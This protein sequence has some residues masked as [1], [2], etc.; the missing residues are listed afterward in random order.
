MI[1]S[2][3]KD[4]SEE[5]PC[6]VC[7]EPLLIFPGDEVA[8]LGGKPGYLC[9]KCASRS[10]EHMEPLTDE[11][12]AYLSE[13]IDRASATLKEIYDDG[14]RRIIR[15]RRKQGGDHGR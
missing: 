8:K 2:Y 14:G 12:H 6:N 4:G 15:E 3:N 5:W 11:E 13:L 9:T 10:K 7:L 1:V